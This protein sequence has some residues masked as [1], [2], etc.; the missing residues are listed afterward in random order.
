MNFDLNGPLSWRYGG[1]LSEREELE[2][3]QDNLKDCVGLPMVHFL[4]WTQSIIILFEKQK[5]HL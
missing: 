3:K 5:T 4:V 2:I 1:C